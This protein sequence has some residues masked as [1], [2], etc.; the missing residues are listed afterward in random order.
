MKILLIVCCFTI[1]TNFVIGQINRPFF[2]IE[3][4]KTIFIASNERGLLNNKLSYEIQPQKNQNLF[5]EIVLKNISSDTLV[6]RN[7]V[8][9]GTTPDHVYITGIGEHELSRSHLFIPGRLPV[10]VICPD[11]AWELGFSCLEN[12]SGKNTVALTRRD[13]NSIQKGQR[14]RFET[15]LFPGG[16]VNYRRWIEE[17]DG[18]WQEGLRI[19]FQQNLL[20]DTTFFDSKLY[21]RKD[22]QW[23]R[24]SYIIHLLQAW[25]KFFYNGVAKQYSILDF[26]QRGKKLYGGDEVVGIW[27]TWPS[28]GLDQRNQFDLFRDLPGGTRQLEKLSVQLKKQATRFFIC[29]NPWDESTRS[30]GHLAG[31]GALIKETKADGVVLDTRGASSKELQQAADKVRSGVIMYSEGMAVPK[32][33]PGIVAGRV[34]NALYYPPMLNLNKFI[35]PSFAIFRVAELYKEP[36]Q[37]ELATS[38]FNGYGTEINM[39]APGQP[40]WVEEQY[41]YL[42][43]TSRIL[44]EHT[45][46]FTSGKYTPLISTTADSIWVNE[47]KQED[48]TIY[49]IYSILPQGYHGKLFSV[50]PSK[51]YHYVDLWHHKLLVPEKDN[52][53]WMVEATTESFHHRWLGT[54]NEGEVDCIAKLPVL[55]QATLNGDILTL[56]AEKGNRIRIWPGQPDYNKLPLE[57][58]IGKKNISLFEKFGAFEGDF[59]I[60]LFDNDILIDETIITIK[61]GTARRISNLPNT[62]KIQIDVSKNI[63][64]DMVLIPSGKFTFKESHGDEFIP[65]PTQDVDSTFSIEPFLMDKFPVTNGQFL[66]FLKATKYRPADPS[67]FLKHWVNGSIKKGEE[68]FPVVY[69]SYEDAQ[70]YAKW[71]QKRLPTELEWQY[72]A[73]TES[74]NEWPWKQTNPVQRKEEVVNETLT[75]TS[76]EGIDSTVCNLGDG[77]LYSVGNY[78]KGTNPFG[79][80]DLVGCVWQLTNDIYYNGSYRYIVLKGGSYFKPSSSWWYVQSGPRELHYRQFLLRV[81]QGFERNGTVGFRCVR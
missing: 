57:L 15:V 64:A 44:R 7:L 62:T 58:T 47:W 27:P 17:Y 61:A 81:S 3:I 48:K 35:K 73:Q 50:Q 13:R 33:M 45:I 75:V 29:Y 71:K 10:N 22:L 5:S 9:F 12:I 65:Y 77:K 72:A 25:D 68:K 1:A 31:L 2:S 24:H 4:D 67:N 34:H 28:L 55:L 80:Q 32:D 46:N 70:A 51:N 6:I 59:I 43:R 39:F 26:I 40:D 56:N 60:Q 37:R 52:N 79:L 63:P 53:D 42:G 23:I 66:Q 76:I 18:N 19:V 11:N 30:E 14:R 20:Y 38:F 41:K 78:P 36:I 8:P 49:T 21:E 69:I 16:S 54:N 74:L